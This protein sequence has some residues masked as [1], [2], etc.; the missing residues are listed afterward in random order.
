MSSQASLIDE[1]FISVRIV[2]MDYY[3]ATPSTDVN[4]HFDPVYS[5][6]RSAPIKKVPILRVFGTTPAGQK[7]CLHIHGIFPYLCKIPLFILVKIFFKVLKSKFFIGT[8]LQFAIFFQMFRCRLV[9]IRASYTDL[10]LAWIK[11]ST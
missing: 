11:P 7:A 3:M 1:A 9:T 5:M 2:T 10:P 8:I 4:N 6:F